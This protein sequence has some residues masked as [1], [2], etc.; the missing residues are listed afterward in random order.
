MNPQT[1]KVDIDLTP[2]IETLR[3]SAD[4]LA[5]IYAGTA[6]TPKA[7]HRAPCVDGSVCGEAAHCP[8]EQ[9]KVLGY[10]IDWLLMPPGRS[11][12][13]LL[14]STVWGD[15][16]VA[17]AELAGAADSGRVVAVVEVPNA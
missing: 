10:T 15:R 16:A 6:P 1:I 17:E 11:P 5:S 13:H 12:E 4:A 14:A 2:L 7:A 3:K 9:P 8:P